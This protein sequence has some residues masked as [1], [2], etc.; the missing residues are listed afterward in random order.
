MATDLQIS[1]F[2]KL[3]TTKEECLPVAFTLEKAGRQTTMRTEATHE[4]SLA[5]PPWSTENTAH[6]WKASFESQ[7][8]GVMHICNPSLS[9]AKSEEC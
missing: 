5:R 7:E 4:G 2:P 9:E 8:D 6:S 3:N 1:F